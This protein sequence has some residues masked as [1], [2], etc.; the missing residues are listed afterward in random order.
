MYPD[1]GRKSARTGM[2]N[3]LFILHDLTHKIKK[4]TKV[5][6]WLGN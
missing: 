2:R 6:L 5:Q 3:K 1:G 4:M